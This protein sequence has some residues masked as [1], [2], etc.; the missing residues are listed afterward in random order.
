MSGS[1]RESPTPLPE[2]GDLGKY[3]NSVEALSNSEKYQLLTQPFVPSKQYK[4][5]QFVKYGKKRSF[6]LSWLEK[7]NGL[8][9]SPLLEGGLCKYCALFAKSRQSLG[10]FVTSP[11]VEFWK[12]SEK[13]K[14]HFGKEGDLGRETHRHALQDALFFKSMME[15]KSQAINVT[16]DRECSRKVEEN[17]KK[18]ASIAKAVIFCGHQNIPLRGHR[19]DSKHIVENAKNTGNFQAL[20]HFGIDAGDKVL[21][22]HFETAGKNCTYRSKT[23]QNQIIEVCGDYIRNKLLKEIRV[24]FF[25]SISAD[26]VADLSNKDQMSLVSRF[27]DSDLNIREE[28]L[29]FA[30][31]DRVTDGETLAGIII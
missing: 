12:A 17:R 1:E 23:T 30:P 14:Q 24:A 27:V 2:S 26:E 10:A 20:L 8:V 16:L 11:F 5:P 6:Q 22:K 9:Y 28:F 4:F 25:F 29:G 15:G 19:D 13:L 21:E 18:L 31:C 7:Y 3:I